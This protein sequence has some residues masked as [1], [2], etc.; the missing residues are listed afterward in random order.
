MPLRVAL[1][2]L[3]Q[4]TGWLLPREVAETPVLVPLGSPC[5]VEHSGSER[6]HCPVRVGLHRPEPSRA[7]QESSSQPCSTAGSSGNSSTRLLCSGPGTQSA[8]HQGRHC[9]GKLQGNGTQHLLSGLLL[10][11]HHTQTIDRDQLNA[12][13][14]IM[15]PDDTCCH[16]WLRTSPDQK[17][18]VCPE[19]QQTVCFLKQEHQVV[20]KFMIHSSPQRSPPQVCITD[21]PD[22][23]TL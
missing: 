7:C 17:V 14:L 3:A 4:G 9:W 10:A 13:I 1:P 12:E 8:R 2:Y 21:K 11:G 18:S 16:P 23:M 5:P 15:T 19:L 6:H 22:L 20:H